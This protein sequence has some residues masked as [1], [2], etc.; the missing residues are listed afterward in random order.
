MT[1]SFL[2]DYNELVAEQKKQMLRLKDKYSDLIAKKVSDEQ[3]GSV[4]TLLTKGIT[5]M[6]KQL[7]EH[8]LRIVQSIEPGVSAEDKEYRELSSG[9]MSNIS[10]VRVC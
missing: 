8:S 6:V 2:K 9:Y 4:L 1:I 7:G 5:W 10:K 3:L